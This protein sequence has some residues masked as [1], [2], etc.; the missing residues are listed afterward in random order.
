MILSRFLHR[1]Q[2]V[3]AVALCCVFSS[4]LRA[5]DDSAILSNLGGGLR[6]L[7]AW[8]SANA[9]SLP[10][11]RRRE[12]VRE[13]LNNTNPHVQMDE[14]GRVVANVHLNGTTPDAIVRAGLEALG[15][16]ILGFEPAGRSTAA[17]HG[18]YSV[19]LPVGQALA[20]SKLAGVQSIML[21]HRPWHHVGV[22]TSQGISVTQAKA[23][24]RLGF[25]GAGIT[26]GVLSDS[27]NLTAPHASVNV[28]HDDLPGHGNPA[29][30]NKPVF[31]L[32]EGAPGEGNIDEGRAML[33]IVHD[34]APDA[35][36]AFSTTGETE[37]V[38]ANAIREMRTN[39]SANCDVLVDDIGFPDEPFFSDGIA[40]KAVEDVVNSTSLA[41]K[42]VL[43][44]SAAGNDGGLGYEADFS[45]VSD[46]SARAGNV[47]A[48]NLQLAQVPT[49]LTAGGFHNFTPGG[50]VNIAQKFIVT[51][52]F[53]ELNFQ[54]NDLFDAAS[55]TS[56]FNVLIFDADGNY[57]S[58]LSGT[59]DNFATGQALELLDLPPSFSGTDLTYQIAITRRSA[60]SGTAQHFRY[61]TDTVA[62]IGGTYLQEG[63]TTIFGHSG[64]RSAD[65]I[66]AYHYSKLAEPELY[67]SFGPVR[68]Y[69]DDA[70][71][72]L[73]TPE[74]RQQPTVSGPDGVATTLASPGLQ[75]F[76]GTSAAAP[77]VAGIAA[78][79]LQAAGG[80]G[81]ISAAQMRAILENSADEHDI[82][83]LMA[84]AQFSSG[85]NTV[86]LT[87]HGD[88]SN[89]STT[90]TSFFT[91]QFTGTGGAQLENVSIDLSTARLKFDPNFFSGFP[92][93]IGDTSGGVDANGVTAVLKT[94]VRGTLK[95]RLVLSFTTFP[96]GGSLSFGIDRDVAR[97]HR[98]GNSADLLE[99]VT[100][101]AAILPPASSQPVPASG[102]F[103][104][105]RGTGY[106][107]ADGFGFVNAE[108]A[109]QAISP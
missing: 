84:T 54:W 36:L 8:H 16:S 7:V 100:V 35:A 30:R 69:F 50:D 66:G 91:L 33:Q 103:Q 47:G 96:A 53:V 97:T 32:H 77:H 81:A 61:I 11:A 79:L 17:R 64:A 14:V 98:G 87:A 26:V 1:I 93:T 99:G 70:G 58:D 49:D 24:Q 56:D 5:E 102:I 9:A 19:Y 86:T 59:D 55:M 15:A 85:N 39:S 83:P 72:R 109:L 52:D 75:T 51:G 76:F 21:A 4:E 3:F 62:G 6:Q 108:A 41:G 57:L 25:T 28:L 65:G 22:V 29:H 34:V 10:Q 27:Y 40:A 92:F 45:P 67:S 90:D 104:N 46:A 80:S 95:S 74:V 88:N 37:V 60:G 20:A 106:T 12:A 13:H 42:K 82:D 18:V 48:N 38:F 2:A 101:S 107:P 89:F 73:D 31:V 105:A 94:G 68:I 44:Y 43:Y 23:V 63:I 78:L 71:N